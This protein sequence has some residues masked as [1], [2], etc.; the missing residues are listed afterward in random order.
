ME[1]IDYQ[2]LIPKFNRYSTENQELL[3]ALGLNGEAGE[4]AEK[5]KKLFRDDV[6]IND[7]RY[8]IAKEL[9]DVMWY[10]CML[11]NNYHLNMEDILDI[12]VNKLETRSHRDM[13]HGSGDDREEHK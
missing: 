6:D 5:I 7:F 2:A 3:L 12:N 13:I 9:G 1:L 10:V 11:A 8:Q 4:V